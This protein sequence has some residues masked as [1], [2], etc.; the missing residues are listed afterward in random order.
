MEGLYLTHIEMQ[1]GE[2]FMEID[3]YMDLL[4]NDTFSELLQVELGY[5]CFPSHVTASGKQIDGP[6][7]DRSHLGDKFVKAVE[8]E[9]WRQYHEGDM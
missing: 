2:E 6:R 3:A 8:Q 4:Y 1:V 9:M 7:L 5:V